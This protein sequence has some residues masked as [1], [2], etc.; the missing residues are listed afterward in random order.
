MPTVPSTAELFDACGIL[1]DPEIEISYNFL[2]YLCPSD[3]RSAYRKKAL[4]TH[5]DRA[6]TLG[7]DEAEM[8]LHFIKAT[9]AY[10]KLITVINNGRPVFSEETSFAKKDIKKTFSKEKPYKKA[11][12]HFF[13]G[14]VPKRKLLLGQF[15]Y[16]LGFISWNTRIN[17]IVWQRRHRPYIGQIALDWGMISTKDIHKILK[18]RDFREKFGESAIRRGYLTP[19]KLMA[20]LGKQ[21]RLQPFI[22]EYFVRHANIT[23]R[24]MEEIVGKQHDHNR[25]VFWGNWR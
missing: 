13:N 15:L 20:L 9:L 11:S 21:R 22:G 8:N 6:K 1:F 2:R 14:K 17:A 24:K 25:K 3:L 16:Y 5:P 7:K 10:E 19:Y 12:S 23:T 18:G 4:E